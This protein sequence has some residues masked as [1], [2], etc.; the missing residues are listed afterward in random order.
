MQPRDVIFRSKQE[1]EE[2]EDK[3]KDKDKDEKEKQSNLH[4]DLYNVSGCDSQFI[5][6]DDKYKQRS[7]YTL[8][9]TSEKLKLVKLCLNYH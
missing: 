5:I 8:I 2:E 3:D 9:N 1:E 4:I 6:K 7:R